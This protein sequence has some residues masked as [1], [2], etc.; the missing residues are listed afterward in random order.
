[1]K[2]ESS[3]QVVGMPGVFAAGDITDWK[4]VKQVAKYA[5]HVSTISANIKEFLTG[6]PSTAVYKSMFEGLAVT[7]GKVRFHSS[8][9]PSLFNWY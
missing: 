8:C 4:E 1:M 9:F 3:L 5:G 7:N 6:K 2:V